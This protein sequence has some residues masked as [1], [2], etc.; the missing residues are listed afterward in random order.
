MV[1]RTGKSYETWWA[2]IEGQNS[3][4]KNRKNLEGFLDWM[5]CALACPD[6]GLKWF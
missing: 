2:A 3:A 1:E 5:D 4:E 6:I